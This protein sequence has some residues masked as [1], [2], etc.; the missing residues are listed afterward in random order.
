MERP[1]FP[2]AP[3]AGERTVKMPESGL[4]RARCSGPIAGFRI[5]ILCLDTIHPLV[6]GNVQHA[7]SFNFP[8][9]YETVRDI[10]VAELMAGDGNALS[11][12][13]AAA[14]RLERAGVS[15]I[16]G[17]CGSF[18]NYQKPVKNA[19]HVPVFMSILTQVPFLLAALPASQ[20][21]G[22]LFASTRSFTPG[23][24]EQCGID[25]SD[26][27]V[28]VG[29]DRL[30]AFGPILAQ[31]TTFDSS[32]LEVE[33]VSLVR[34]TTRQHPDIGAWLLQ[35]SDL[36]PYAAAIQRAT[37]LPL[38]DMCTLVEHIQRALARADYRD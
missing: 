12:I 5:G 11:P 6:R 10:S 17:A 29:A 3:L 19:M 1:D 24:M 30:P 26:R 22:I 23:L 28:A 33:L 15:A 32:A 14:S 7:G 31:Q 13:L 16:V 38:F 2:G 27:I 35:C 21:L 34:D 4:T 8:V 37:E 18:A 20:K 36:P 25:D 9:L